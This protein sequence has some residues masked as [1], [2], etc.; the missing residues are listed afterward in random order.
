MT[1]GLRWAVAVALVAAA[2]AGCARVDVLAGRLADMPDAVRQPLGDCLWEHGS[3]YAWARHDTLRLEITRTEHNP[4][5]DRVSREV[6]RLSPADGH[7]RIDKPDLRQVIAADGLG[8][9]V[10]VDGRE[11]SDLELRA[12]AAADALLIRQVMPLPFS[13]LAPGLTIQHLKVRTGPA[14]AKTW[15]QLLVTGLADGAKADRMI[16][17]IDRATH[18]LEAVVLAWQ[19][20]PFLGRS[21]RM[22]MDEWWP[23]DGLRLSHRWRLAAV[24]DSGAARDRPQ[25]TFQ[26][27]A[28]AWDSSGP[29]VPTAK[30]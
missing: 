21:Y 14:E 4:A 18:R 23:V 10:L 11:T 22:T 27:T 13:L 16:V 15:D 17:E 26:V 7:F 5:G 25:W 6:W 28:A 9:R 12:D 3:F 20:S 1:R 2:G 30:P 8:F 24:D 19:E 29:A